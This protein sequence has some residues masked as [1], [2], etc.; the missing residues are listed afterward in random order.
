[1]V[2]HVS[3]GYHVIDHHNVH[4]LVLRLFSR[5][6][7]LCHR[8]LIHYVLIISNQLAPCDGVRLA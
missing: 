8:A 1:M 2:T 3:L 5:S 4:R 7:N 6:Q